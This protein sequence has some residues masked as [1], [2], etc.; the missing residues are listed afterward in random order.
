MS[1]RARAHVS[2]CLQ[3]RPWLLPPC[4]VRR[5]LLTTKKKSCWEAPGWLFSDPSQSSWAP[6]P[7]LWG[8]HDLGL[9]L[10]L[11]VCRPL[12]PAV[13]WK[14]GQLG[15]RCALWLGTARHCCYTV[16]TRPLGLAAG[17]TVQGG[18]ARGRGHSVL[19]RARA[20]RPPPGVTLA[21]RTAAGPPGRTGWGGRVSLFVMCPPCVRCN[22]LKKRVYREL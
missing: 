19:S 11:R 5:G 20:A 4:P 8:R 15:S 14:P 6:R 13:C 21:F 12:W 1:A 9:A 18:P 22:D 2:L 17:P 7:V 3:T 10:F 16:R